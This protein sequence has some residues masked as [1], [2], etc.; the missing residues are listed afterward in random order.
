MTLQLNY[1][2]ELDPDNTPVI[3]SFTDIPKPPPTSIGAD[4]SPASPPCLGETERGHDPQ[5]TITL[6][7]QSIHDILTALDSANA[8]IT[9]TETLADDLDTIANSLTS[10]ANKLRHTANNIRTNRQ[11]VN[12]TLYPA[13]ATLRQLLSQHP[14]VLH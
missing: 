9:H 11:K 5:T 2:P 14:E 7:R 3:K 12:A 13:T 4:E 10:I 1:P 8:V 6:P